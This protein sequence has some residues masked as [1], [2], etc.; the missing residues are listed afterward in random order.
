MHWGFT[1]QAHAYL[2]DTK[3]A[4]SGFHWLEHLPA[5]VWWIL[6]QNSNHPHSRPPRV[7]ITD[8][9]GLRATFRL[10]SGSG[11]KQIMHFTCC[12]EVAVAQDEARC[13]RF[14]LQDQPVDPRLS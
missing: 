8:R 3:L 12:N 2:P 6:F 10:E 5:I 14:S 11:Q 1:Q 9:Q 13:C 7:L 4:V